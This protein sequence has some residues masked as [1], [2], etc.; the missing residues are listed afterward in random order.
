MTAKEYIEKMVD[1]FEIQGCFA[2]I[3]PEVPKCMYRTKNGLK[4]IVGQGIDDTFYSEPLEQSSVE[5]PN[6]FNAV[7]L[8]FIKAGGIGELPR[9]LLE[10]LQE[11]H[12]SDYNRLEVLF[13]SVVQQM[14]SNVSIWFGGE[15]K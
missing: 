10:S 3:S 2:I 14:R 7:K 13:E 11:I 12:D 9:N 8:S 5:S 6:V 4:C 1:D 15:S